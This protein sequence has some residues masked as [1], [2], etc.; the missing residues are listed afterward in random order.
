MHYN[1]QQQQQIKSL[2]LAHCT[3]VYT[4]VAHHQHAEQWSSYHTVWCHLR[5]D[6]PADIHPGPFPA[7]FQKLES[8]TSL[9]CWSILLVMFS[10][11][12]SC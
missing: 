11:V 6:I 12:C 9:M 10:A 3:A 5:L 7:A 8:S 1:V 2:T 4:P